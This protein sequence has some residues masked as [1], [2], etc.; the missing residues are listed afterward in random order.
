MNHP[1]RNPRPGHKPPGA[2]RAKPRRLEDGFQKAVVQFLELALPLGCWWKAIPNGGYRNKATA[3]G[4]KATGTKA[5]AP[6]LEILW[7]GVLHGLELK[8]ER[9]KPSAEQEAVRDRFI[10]SGGK[11]AWVND[12]AGVEGVER[13][14]IEWGIPLRATAYACGVVR[15]VHG[16]LVRRA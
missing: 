8:V 1:L 11:W 5:G 10:A 15:S 14:L 12:A 16:P 13:Q 7:G 2:K 6:D 3:G 4:M 9:N